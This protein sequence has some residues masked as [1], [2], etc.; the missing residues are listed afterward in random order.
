MTKITKTV[1]PLQITIKK[2]ST[3][4]QDEFD[5]SYYQKLS[6]ANKV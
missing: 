6:K 4:L 5:F 1:G 2:K 3:K